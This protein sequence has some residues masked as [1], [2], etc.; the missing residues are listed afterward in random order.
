MQQ[1]D[2]R[3]SDRIRT[4]RRSCCKNAVR[5][6]VRRWRPDQ[7]EPVLSIQAIKHPK[8]DQMRKALDICQA[9]LKRFEDFE[10]PLDLM[11]GAQT[12]GHFLRGLVRATHVSD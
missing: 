2:H 8:Y 1:F 3:Q 6:I 11:F 12:L 7:F 10:T 9:G 5:T 4:T